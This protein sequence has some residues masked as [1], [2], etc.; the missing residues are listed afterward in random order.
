MPFQLSCLAVNSTRWYVLDSSLPLSKC[1]KKKVKQNRFSL[2]PGVTICFVKLLQS[3]PKFSSHVV[4]FRLSVVRE[5]GKKIYKYE[6]AIV[7]QHKLRNHLKIVTVLF[8]SRSAL[9]TT[10]QQVNADCKCYMQMNVRHL[11]GAAGSLNFFFN[12]AK[13]GEC[14]DSVQWRYCSG[15]FFILFFTFLGLRVKTVR[16]SA[17]FHANNHVKSSVPF[18]QKLC[19]PAVLFM[20]VW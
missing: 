20:I 5:E 16:F 8:S 4:S 19:S 2:C 18:C 9:L 11:G 15:W 17:W 6:H 7:Q 3:E 12:W 13:R 1:L 14:V 10:G